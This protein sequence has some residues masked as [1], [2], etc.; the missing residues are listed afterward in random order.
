MRTRDTST[1]DLFGWTGGK[2]A[3]D[4]GMKRA[5]RGGG[6][7][8]QAALAVVHGLPAG[9]E[10]KFEDLTRLVRKT[11]GPPPKSSNI[12]GALA[13]AAMRRQW[14]VKT[15]KRQHMEKTTSHS[16]ITD[17]LRRTLLK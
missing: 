8:W 3:R 13:N 14:L 16:R 5:V 9:W 15:G 10:G 7:W 11:I 12:F 2:A 6:D 1:G 4:E 17:V